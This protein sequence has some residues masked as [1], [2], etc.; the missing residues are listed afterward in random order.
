MP[1]N[2][3]PVLQ[4]I[5]ASTRPGR[6]GKAIGDWFAQAA[7]ENGKFEVQVADLAEINLPFMDEPNHPRMQKYQHQHT[8]DWSARI[9][10]SDA[11]VFVEPEY[12]HGIC[13][14]LKNALD[15]LFLEWNDKPAGIVSYGG[16]SGG[17][18]AAQHTKPVLNALNIMAINGAVT[19]PF[20]NT[21]LKDGKFEPNDTVQQS[22]NPMLEQLYTWA[23]TLREMRQKT[24]QETK[25]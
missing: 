25:K 23:V 14:P 24:A 21:M 2:K 7:R 16:V 1:D 6:A 10:G 20:F 19:I 13:A 3:K 5:I 11:F 8:K 17:L 22:V 9:A 12:N 4:V 15:Y 18:R